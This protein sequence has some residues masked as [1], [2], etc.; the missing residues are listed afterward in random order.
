MIPLHLTTPQFDT[1]RLSLDSWQPDQC[2]SYSSP[3]N[4]KTTKTVYYR[5]QDFCYRW[6]GLVPELQLSALSFSHRD[7]HEP[8][9]TALQPGLAKKPILVPETQPYVSLTSIIFMLHDKLLPTQWLKLLHTFI[10]QFWQVRS[11]GTAELGFLH[12]QEV[13]MKVLAR[14]ASHQK[15]D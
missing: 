15:L 10:S 11:H 2:L 9:L 4:T 3:K 1:L 14:A 6:H 12:T 8:P 13:A 7:W 5:A